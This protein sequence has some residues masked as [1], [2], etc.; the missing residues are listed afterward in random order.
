MEGHRGASRGIAGHSGAT[1]TSPA[2]ISPK[3]PKSKRETYPQTHL[4]HPL[5]ISV[6]FP[7]EAIELD[8][9]GNARNIV[10]GSAGSVALRSAPAPLSEQCP[11]AQT[12]KQRAPQCLRAWR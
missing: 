1:K 12:K 3:P 11:N 2:P 5:A 7:P 8:R 4:S 10:S 6:F 9:R